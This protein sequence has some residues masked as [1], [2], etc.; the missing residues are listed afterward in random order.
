MMFLSSSFEMSGLP[1][2]RWTDCESERK[3]PEVTL[4]SDSFLLSSRTTG[5]QGN[6]NNETVAGKELPDVMR[7][8]LVSIEQMESIRVV[9][10]WTLYLHGGGG[11]RNPSSSASER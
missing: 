3:Y 5:S 6:A 11:E 4:P 9:L 1:F 7:I 8:S 2:L 10:I